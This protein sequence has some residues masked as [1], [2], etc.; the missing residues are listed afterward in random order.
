[1]SYIPGLKGVIAAETNLS[2][3]DGEAGEL[4][5]AG[6]RLGEIAPHATFE[7]MI[8]LLWHHRLPSHSDLG[9]FS[10]ALKSHRT[11]PNATTVLLREAASQNVSVIDALRM[12]TATLSLIS[13][14]DDASDAQKLVA[15]AP[16][17]R[18]AS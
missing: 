15:K 18:G 2:S 3:V 11:L 4:I 5:I 7:E 8:Y 13:D 14:H 9:T 17:E 12:A 6:Y 1:M 16:H 10:E